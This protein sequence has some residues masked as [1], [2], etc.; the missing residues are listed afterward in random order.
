VTLIPNS[1]SAFN[2]TEQTGTG[3]KFNPCPT[4]AS[5]C[6]GG[7]SCSL[8][9]Q[10][11]SEDSSC[12]T[13]VAS[14]ALGEPS[15]AW[16]VRLCF[17]PCLRTSFYVLPSFQCYQLLPALGP[18]S[19]CVPPHF[20]K[21]EQFRSLSQ[22]PAHLVLVAH[23]APLARSGFSALVAT[24]QRPA[25]S[26]WPAPTASQPSL[27]PPSPTRHALRRSAALAVVAEAAALVRVG[28]TPLVVI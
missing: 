24:S 14:V 15:P 8:T 2:T 26:A 6:G 1:T 10:I 19:T 9:F 11:Q 22:R 18:I 17:V 23:S 21:T 7:S 28:F 3:A 4:L 5:V 16:V 20:N 25:Q 13:A 12:C 27:Q